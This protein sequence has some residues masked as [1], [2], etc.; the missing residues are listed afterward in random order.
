MGKE[1]VSLNN[2]FKGKDY[3]SI[4]VFRALQLGDM[5]CIV[6]AL[7]ALRS[8]YPEAQITLI[9]L[10]WA[11]QFVER[12]DYLLDDFIEFPGF[13]GF[14]ERAP[15][16]DLIPQ[17]LT[18]VHWLEFELAL[19]MQGS[20]GIANSLVEL[21]GAD[22][23][24]G[25]YLPGE[26]CP[27]PE[28]YLV[29]PANEP[30]VWRHLRLMEHL[31]L[32]LQGDELEFPLYAQD[33]E[34]YNCLKASYGLQA[35]GFVCLHP[36]ARSESRRWPLTRFAEVGDA[37]AKRGLQVVLTGTAE[38]AHLTAEVAAAMSAP[39]VDLSGQTQLGSLG[40]LLS[41]ARL[42]VSNDTGVYHLASALLTPSVV[43]FSASDPNRWAPL[44]QR[45]HRAVAWA[46]A[47]IP[48]VVLAEADDLLQ[49]ERVHVP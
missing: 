34:A 47:A 15:Q 26:Y 35:D 46:T 25:F 5:L 9:S 42:L 22:T 24:A 36:G 38:E 23:S 21:F 6:P 7:R 16:I 18:E 32:P 39:S 45:L 14:P 20:G 10:P 4:A 43:L 48:D 41:E 19:Q 2:L 17:F 12:F 30:E 37:L 8:A 29:Y 28:R 49:R 44:D 33:W 11:K 40:A 13:P 3:K 27:D 31:G 1:S